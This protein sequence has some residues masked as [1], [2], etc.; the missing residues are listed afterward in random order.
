MV[1]T[2]LFVLDIDCRIL[3]LSLV[4]FSLLLLFNFV[5]KK[6]TFTILISNDG[7]IVRNIIICTLYNF[8]VYLYYIISNF[9]KK[10]RS[11]E[12]EHGDMSIKVNDLLRKVSPILR[13]TIHRESYFSPRDC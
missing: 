3:E 1:K 2:K 9:K 6:L 5:N 7:Y 11:Y 10:C 8:T 13:L 12:S 4:F